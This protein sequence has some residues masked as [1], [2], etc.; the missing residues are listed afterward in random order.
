MYDNELLFAMSD[1][2]DKKLEQ[3]YD[4]LERIEGL[5]ENKILFQLQAMEACY[6]SANE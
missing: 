4:E 3:I 2:L 1:M 5:Q 6:T